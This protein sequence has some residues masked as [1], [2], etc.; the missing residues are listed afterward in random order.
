MSAA[1][2]SSL[3]RVSPCSLQQ[4]GQV[5]QG[6]QDAVEQEGETHNKSNIGGATA[7]PLQ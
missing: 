3:L 2:F 7:L 5:R 6:M 1:F 4:G